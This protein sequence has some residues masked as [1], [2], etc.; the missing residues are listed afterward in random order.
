MSPLK[1]LKFGLRG[2]FRR[3]QV[4]SELNDELQAYLEHALERNVLAGMD[5]EAALRLGRAEKGSG[6]AG[7]EQVHPAGWESAP[8]SAWQDPPEGARRFLKQPGFPFL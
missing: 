1:D 8:E 2:L 3:K 6:A 5:P 4:E 7:K